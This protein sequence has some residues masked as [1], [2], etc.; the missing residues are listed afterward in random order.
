MDNGTSH[1]TTSAVSFRPERGQAIATT[2]QRR[3]S[4]ARRPK[5]LKRGLGQGG[6]MARYLS[7]K[8]RSISKAFG[9]KE[10]CRSGEAS[11]EFHFGQLSDEWPA[12]TAFA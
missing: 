9:G 2:R 1:Y 11:M 7:L 10:K 5:H 12:G 4:W 3:S 6:S 8:F